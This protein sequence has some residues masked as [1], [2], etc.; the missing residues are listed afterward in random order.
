MSHLIGYMLIRKA[1]PTE[2]EQ[3]ASLRSAGVPVDK[4]Y[5]PLYVDRWSPRRRQNGKDDPLPDRTLMIEKIHQGDVV[6][7]HS[8]ACFAITAADAR[9]AMI[10]VI[11]KRAAGIRIVSTKTFLKTRPEVAEW[12]LVADSVTLEAKRAVAAKARE[13]AKESGNPGAAVRRITPEQYERMEPI[14]KQ[15]GMT[16]AQKVAMISATIAPVSQRTL[17]WKFGRS[18]PEKKARKGK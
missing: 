6:V 17:G 11:T 1:G 4:P 13:G 2:E 9:Q 16:I 12:F 7:I 18:T 8:A 15:K 14:W 3:R 5:P 10:R